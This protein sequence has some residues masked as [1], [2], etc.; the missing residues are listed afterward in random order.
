MWTDCVIHADTPIDAKHP[1]NKPISYWFTNT[2]DEGRDAFPASF[3]LNSFGSK[4]FGAHGALY[5]V[6]WLTA[7]PGA[8][9]RSG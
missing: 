8:D 1:S 7:G 2:S 4:N 5:F 3:A 9:G 6:D